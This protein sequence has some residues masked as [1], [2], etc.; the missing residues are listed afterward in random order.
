MNIQTVSRG[1][2]SIIQ[3]NRTALYFLTQGLIQE[4]SITGNLEFILAVGSSSPDSPLAE[5]LSLQGRA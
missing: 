3:V 2:T 1:Q 4:I 5:L